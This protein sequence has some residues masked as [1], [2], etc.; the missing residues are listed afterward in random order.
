MERPLK[1]KPDVKDKHTFCPYAKRHHIK[2]ARP[3]I[4]AIETHMHLDKGKILT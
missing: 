2:T 1:R 4:H 3:R